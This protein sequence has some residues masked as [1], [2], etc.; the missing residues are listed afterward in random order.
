MQPTPSAPIGTAATFD[1][2]L[3]IAD[4]P[5]SQ[6][7]AALRYLQEWIAEHF[8]VDNVIWVGTA[9]VLRGAR[10]KA[11]PFLGWR[12]RD[13]VALRPSPSTTR[14]NIAGNSPN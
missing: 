3:R 12:L 13:R 4:F 6:T 10:A 1:L 11:D 5:A 2:W 9:R 7:D 8:E 14:A